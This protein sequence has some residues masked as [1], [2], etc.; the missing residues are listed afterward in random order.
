MPEA[1][2]ERCGGGGSVCPVAGNDHRPADPEL[3]GL[4]GAD[5][6]AA[7]VHDDDL[8]AR[9]RHADGVGMGARL[10]GGII[11]VGEVVSVAP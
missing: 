8:G 5:I 6:A 10:A 11:V 9:Q 4:A 1:G 7:I 2:G 3:A